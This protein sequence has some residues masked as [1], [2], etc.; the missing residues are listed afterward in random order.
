MNPKHKINK[1]ISVTIAT[2][3]FGTYAQSVNPNVE[4]YSTVQIVTP[5]KKVKPKAMVEPDMEEYLK[6]DETLETEDVCIGLGAAIAIRV[7]GVDTNGK[8]IVKKGPTF[9][10]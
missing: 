6:P 3:C 10:A 4:Q 9:Y 1:M 7:I 8:V 2:S 5:P